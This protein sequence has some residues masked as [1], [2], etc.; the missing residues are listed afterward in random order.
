MCWFRTTASASSPQILLPHPKVQATYLHRAIAA[1][2]PIALLKDREANTLAQWLEQHRGI[3][4]LSRDRSATYRSGMN[5]GAPQAMQV[6]DRFHLL[7]NFTLVLEQF[8]RILQNPTIDRRIIDFHA[9]LLHHLLQVSLEGVTAVPSH[10]QQDDF[11][12]K[13]PPLK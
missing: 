10:V 13:V 9:R 12:Q 8:W 4:V 2:R 6:A 11:R 5:Q 7:Q 3:K 1:E